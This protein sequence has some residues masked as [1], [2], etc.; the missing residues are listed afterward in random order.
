MFCTYNLPCYGCSKGHITCPVTCYAPLIPITA[1]T[2]NLTVFMWPGLLCLFFLIPFTRAQMEG[3]C[4]DLPDLT[5]GLCATM[6]QLQ[7]HSAKSHMT[8]M[9]KQYKGYG[10]GSLSACGMPNSHLNK[11]PTLT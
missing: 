7:D 1:F 11:E 9:V 5:W 4:G 10:S 2:L 3:S 6:Y 8:I